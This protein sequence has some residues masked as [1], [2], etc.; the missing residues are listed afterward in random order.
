[1]PK[2]HSLPGIRSSR[3]ALK[4]CEPTAVRASCKQRQAVQDSP[5]VSTAL[6]CILEV[7]SASEHD[8]RHAAVC[9]DM[10]FQERTANQLLQPL[11]N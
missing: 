10:A 5:Q 11:T 2:V 7:I 9:L 4:L 1:M 8:N 6:E 3:L